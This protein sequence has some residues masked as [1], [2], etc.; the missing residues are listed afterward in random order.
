MKMIRCY[1]RYEKLEEV[2]EKLFLLGV[3]GL[4]VNEVKGIGKPLSQI[5]S[6]PD[7]KTAKLPQFLP[8]VEITLVLDDEEVDEVVKV[9][10]ETLRTGNL[11]D[12]KIFILPVEETIR[13]RTGET[14]KQALY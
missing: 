2:R 12:G 13:V 6:D 8:R 4:S 9:L 10:V 14:G 5:R 11:G 7:P 3:P 1:I